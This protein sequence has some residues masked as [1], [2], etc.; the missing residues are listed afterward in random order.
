MKS[1]KYRIRVLFAALFCVPTFAGFVLASDTGRSR[2]WVAS[3]EDGIYTG[4]LD[5]KT[6][7]VKNFIRSTE[8]LAASYIARHPNKSILYAVSR[9]ESGGQLSSYRVQENGEL[10]LQ[11]TLQSRPGGGAHITASNDGLWLAVA[12]YSSGVTGVYKLEP[13]G[14]IG[15]VFDEA[16]HSGS[17]VDAERQAAPHPHWVGFSTDSR[18]LYVPD[19]GTDQI[20]VYEV[21]RDNAGLHVHQKAATPRGAGPRHLAFHPTSEF[22]YVSDELQAAVSRYVHDPENGNLTYVDSTTSAEEASDETWHNVS[23]IRVHPGGQFLYV[24]NRGYDYVSVF[25]INSRTGALVPIEREAIRGTV[26]RNMNF[27]GSG[28]WALVAGTESDTLG[29]FAVDLTSGELTFSG[30]VLPVT[31]PMAIVF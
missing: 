17:S 9:S 7:K 31:S 13:D 23:D 22:A 19:L 28:R 27:D 16:Q 1:V 6:G 10:E 25:D 30:Q 18:F 5:L 21:D 4:E 2:F 3:S 14:R 11:S 26:S 15:E 20:W 8:G 24:V 12:Y 29:V